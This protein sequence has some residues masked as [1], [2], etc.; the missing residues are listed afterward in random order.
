MSESPLAV[1]LRLRESDVVRACGLAA[2]ARGLDLAGRHLIRGGRRVGGR[3][4]GEVQLEGDAYAAA[5]LEILDDAPMPTFR[6]GCSCAPTTAGASGPETADP[7]PAAGELACAHVAAVLT[8]WIRHPADFAAADAAVDTAPRMRPI[9]AGALARAP[10][11]AAAPLTP[12]PSAT[13]PP[14]PAPRH[15]A[16]RDELERLPESELRAVAERILGTEYAPESERRALIER[17]GVTLGDP[18]QMTQILRRI[19]PAALAFAQAIALLGGGLT[20]AELDG[21]A[22]RAGVGRTYMEACVAVLERHG[23]LFRAAGSAPP[24][25]LTSDR[26]WRRFSGWHLPAEIAAALGRSLPAFP[27]PGASVTDGDATAPP[28]YGRVQRATARPLCATLA[29]LSHSPAPLRP[30]SP[31]VRALAPTE[32]TTPARGHRLPLVPGDPPAAALAAWARGARV[33]LGL[34]R[35]ARRAL[36]WALDTG[37]ADH[38]FAA[39]D[40]LPHAEWP[41]ALRAG[42]A[43]WLAAASHAEL[44]DLALEADGVQARCDPAHPALRPATLAAENAAARRFVARLLM[45]APVGTWIT[46]DRLLDLVWWLD[47]FFLRGRELALGAPSWWLA[48][49]ADGRMLRAD[50]R[51]EWR[52]ADARYLLALLTGPFHWWGVIDLAGDRGGPPR[53]LRVTPFGAFL[54]GASERAPGALDALAAGWGAAVLPTREGALAV[55]PLA[56]G[57]A[58]LD[59]LAPW[60]DVAGV[61]GGRLILRPSPDRICRALDAGLDPAAA[62]TQ[63]RALDTRDH[64]QAAAALGAA[65]DGCRARYGHARITS[66]QT[67]LEADDAAT[68]QEALAAA[69][70]VAARTCLLAP[71]LALAAAADHAELEAALNRRGFVV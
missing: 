62:L 18:A 44:V 28:R 4:S 46:V 15:L 65:L 17:L 59:A 50:S 48:D 32:P 25:A 8:Q 41:L 3:I 10:A 64:T 42:F 16:L 58:L 60:A 43:V 34:A 33:P 21:M 63:L 1:L 22:Q 6:W 27:V 54:L 35:M 13:S 30:G 9:D 61:A 5:W 37:G 26:T 66:G 67:L 40:R 36:L 20:A 56:A 7:P 24:V 52:R 2:A 31:V 38:P 29:L 45:Y 12:E 47:P 49:T 51:E 19:D 71:H 70:A 39:L 11:A 68:L 69:P 53:A 14:L 55:Q 23:L 57:P